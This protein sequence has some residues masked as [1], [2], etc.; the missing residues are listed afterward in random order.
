MW[1]EGLT[2]GRVIAPVQVGQQVEGD[3]VGS[4]GD[5]GSTQEGDAGG[6]DGRGRLIPAGHGVVVGQP[7]NVKTGP[8]RLGHELGG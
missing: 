6:G 5:L 3:A 8:G 2:Q 1:G 4:A 7:D